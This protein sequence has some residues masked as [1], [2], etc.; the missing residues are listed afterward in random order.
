VKKFF[1]KSFLFVIILLGCSY[2]LDFAIS[3]G[4]SNMQDYRFQSWND[5]IQSE[6]NADIIVNGN[7]RGLSHFNV[8]ILEEV[9]NCNAYNLSIGGHPF[10]IQNM[11]YNFYLEHNKPPSVIIQNVDFLTINSAQVIGHEREQ[12][13]PYI[14]DSFLQTHLHDFGFS[15]MELYLPLIRYFGYQMV[16]KNGLLQFL[17]LRNYN[18]HPSYKGFY[19][20]KGQ[21]N[22]TELNRL[23]DITFE[24]DTAAAKLF[25]QY[26]TDCKKNEIKV[27][28]V[29][30][31]VYYR[32][33][34]KVS[35]RD[36]MTD[37]FQD[38]STKNGH[39]YLDYTKDDICLDSTNFSV[40]VHL[41][42]KGA[43]KFTRKLANDLDSLGIFSKN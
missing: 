34:N 4:L 42:E 24:T 15:K 40:S 17:K 32:A 23:E 43:A 8:E 41:N 2:G 30:S 5:V 39:I 3:N 6:V 25:E 16:I 29:N 11:K 33:M 13:F 1:L 20:E 22:P 36:S 37:Y 27:I 7:S 35:N 18:S 14:F 9:L 26:L 12:V 21:W 10:N 19:P 31:P 28:L 38:I